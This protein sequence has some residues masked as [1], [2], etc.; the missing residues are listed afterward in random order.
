LPSPLT[1]PLRALA[2]IGGWGVF[3]ASARLGADSQKHIDVGRPGRGEEHVRRKRAAAIK[4]S[5]SPPLSPFVFIVRLR[6]DSQK[7]IDLAL[8][9]PPRALTEKEEDEE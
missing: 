4:S 7:Y 8:T 2:K 3:S 9:S 6:A 5:M 1:S